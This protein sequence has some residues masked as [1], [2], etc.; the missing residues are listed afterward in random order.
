[1]IAYKLVTAQMRSLPQTPMLYAHTYRLGVCET[2]MKDTFGFFC[3]RDLKT[4]VKVAKLLK[5]CNYKVLKVDGHKPMPKH[6]YYARL[7]RIGLNDFYERLSAGGK[8]L[9][10]EVENEEPDLVLFEKVTPICVMEGKQYG[11]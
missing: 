8:F 4:A 11:S 10:W 6:A 7:S 3:Y 1:M 9:E 5:G 2:A